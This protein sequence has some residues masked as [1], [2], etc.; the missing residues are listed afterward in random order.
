MALT[1][2]GT[3]LSAVVEQTVLP[4]GTTGHAYSTLLTKHQVRLALPTKP[5]DLTLVRTLEMV[6]WPRLLKVVAN[7]YNLNVSSL[8]GL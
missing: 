5:T 7:F 4:G 3:Q 1:P 2:D 8:V 6:V